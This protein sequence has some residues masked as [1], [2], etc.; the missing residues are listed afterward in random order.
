MVTLL[1][2]DR[3]HLTFEDLRGF[4]AEGYIRDSTLDQRDGFGPDIQRRNIQRFAETYGLVLGNRSYTEYV[5]GWK[6]K[7]RPEL[8]QFLD[9][10][11][12]DR[13]DVLLVDHTSRFGRNQEECIRY[14]SELQ[15]LEKVV[16][17]VSQGIISGSDRDF[18][19]E[20]INETLDEQYSRNLS[21]YVSAG[22]AE[23]AANGYTNGVP[24]L[25][26][27]S[28]KLASDKRERKVPDTKTIPILRA[29]LQD[30]STGR[31][32]FKDVAD[33]LNTRG[34]R[35][36]NDRP[37]TGAS[38]RD[39]LGNRFYEGKVVY[40]KGQPDGEVRQG[41]HEVADDIK[42][43]WLRCQEVKQE[44]R[45][46]AAGRPRGPARH[47]PFSR[48]LACHRCGQ[49]YYGEAVGKPQHVELRLSHERRGPVKHCDAWPRS[50]SVDALNSQ[51]AE[52]VLC[53]V[54]LDSSWKDRVLAALL[55]EEP[56][57]ADQDQAVRLQQAIGNLQK[58]HLWGD[59]TDED[60]RRERAALER[61]LKLVA[62]AP[63]TAQLPNLERAAGLL[64]HLPDLWSHP[65]VTNEKREQLVREVFA[66]ITIDG[67]TL[68]AIEPKPAYVPLF[69]SMIV[70][71]KFG[72]RAFESPPSP[73]ITWTLLIQHRS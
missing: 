35:T 48:V 13:Y 10:A 31:F 18:L 9:D 45:L 1:K 22:M 58:Q 69:A 53:Y 61:Q 71:Q 28:E 26:Y 62:P 20:R 8:Q 6:A 41:V 68:T 59:L 16:V 12:L 60:Y 73:P 38:V 51:F 27:R 37:F 23:K 43:L 49:P 63:Q 42:H 54:Q 52:R 65:G 25:G 40:H 24:P 5:S 14:K 70:S 44:R 21:R 64:Q 56:Q 4:R 50:R 19:N 30:Y 39:V 15:R 32:S 46:T 66:R 72:Y 34:F 2:T 7:K 36:R 67:K 47:Y 29:L 57:P 17:F 33:S 11:H 55:Q 3:L